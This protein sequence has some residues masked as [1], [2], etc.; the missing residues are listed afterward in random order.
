MNGTRSSDATEEARI[1]EVYEHRAGDDRYSWFNDGHQMIIQSAERA[2]LRSLRRA[3]I[4][5]LA[6][7]TILEVGCGTGQWIR[8]LVR[9][10]AQ[11]SRV[12]GVDLLADRI[13]SARRLCA[14]GSTL[15]AGSAAKLPFPDASFDIVLQST[16][17]T[18]ILDDQLRAHAA[19][20]MLRVLR[21]S[22]VLLWYDFFVD[23]PRNPDVRAVRRRDLER[24]FPACALDL[25]RTTLAPPIARWIAPRSW[26]A[27]TVL[28]VFPF[29]CTHYAGTIRRSGR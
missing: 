12:T 10:G 22:G 29:L 19:A 13:A 18:S 5:S 14:P 20:E 3:G 27:G 2:L 16:V 8:A 15:L 21:P 24:L 11:P 4:T 26:V 6:D 7:R 9:W 17:F 25:R 23:N 28:S 1:R